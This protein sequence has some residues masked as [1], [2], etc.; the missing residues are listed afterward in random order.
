MGILNFFKKPKNTISKNG[1]NLIYSEI[2]GDLLYAFN[3]N[4]DKIEGLFQIFYE[5]KDSG[6]NNNYNKKN[7]G[8]VFQEY[9]FINGLPNGFFKEY[10]SQSILITHIDNV[11]SNTFDFNV[12]NTN[13]DLGIKF[14]FSNRYLINGIVSKYSNLNG[15]SKLKRE[16]DYGD[17]ILISQKQFYD[18]G[19]LYFDTKLKKYYYP[20]GTLKKDEKTGLS[21][22]ENGNLKED[23][24]DLKFY[25]PNGVL[26][27]DLKKGIENYENGNLKIDNLIGAEFYK[28]KKSSYSM[29]NKINSLDDALKKTDVLKLLTYNNYFKDIFIY[30][31]NGKLISNDEIDRKFW[32]STYEYVNNNKEINHEKVESNIGDDMPKIQYSKSLSTTVIETKY[33]GPL[34]INGYCLEIKEEVY[35]D[36]LNGII[37][38]NYKLIQFN[39]TYNNHNYINGIQQ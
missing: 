20:D 3:K 19:Q 14:H 21:F 34:I 33:F 9:N 2:S 38:S 28:S 31:Q 4:D 8:F 39:G 17:N 15:K 24:T 26:R 11:K 25:Y 29:F 23:I 5:V 7:I 12:S 10:D 22:Y 27:C 32:V 6:I 13:S 36:Y 35:E 37:F 16:F 18:N 1:L 30:D